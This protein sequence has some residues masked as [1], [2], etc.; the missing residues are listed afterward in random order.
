[1]YFILFITAFTILMY[2]WFVEKN[3]SKL[4]KDILIALILTLDLILILNYI[5]VNIYFYDNTSLKYLFYTAL[6]GIPIHLRLDCLHR[7]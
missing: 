1:M 3:S 6:T 5:L 2:S 7:G 4:T